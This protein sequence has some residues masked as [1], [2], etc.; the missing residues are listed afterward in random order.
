MMLQMLHHTLSKIFVHVN[1]YPGGS[2]RTVAIKIRVITAPHM[3]KVR[4]GEYQF[5]RSE[6]LDT[7][8]NKPGTSSLQYYKQLVFGMRMPYRIKMLFCKMP[9]YKYLWRRNGWFVK[10]GFQT[11]LSCRA[12]TKLKTNHDKIQSDLDKIPIGCFVQFIEIRFVFL[13]IN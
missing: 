11:C 3:W 4:S 2:D 12:G 9:Y 7:V 1:H 6:R 5:S 13:T 10:C 8:T